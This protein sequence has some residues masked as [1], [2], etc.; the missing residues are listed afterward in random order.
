MSVRDEYFNFE[1]E[2]EQPKDDLFSKII[3]SLVIVFLLVAIVAVSIIS[4]KFISNDKQEVKNNLISN[5]T[6]QQSHPKL[7][8]EQKEKDNKEQKKNIKAIVE[9]KSNTQALKKE[10]I[11]LI[12]KAVLEQ[13]QKNSQKVVRANI[14]DNQKKEESEDSKLLSSLQQ[15]RPDIEEKKQEEQKKKIEKVKKKIV[16]KKIKDKIIRKHITYNAVIIDNKAVKSID[17]LSKLYAKINR[18][19]KR[20]K[21][22]ILKNAYT[23]KI[24]KEIIIRQNAMRIITVRKGDTLGSIARRAYGKASMYKKI[25][26][27]NP[28]ILSNPHSLKVGMKLRVPR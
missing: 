26:K 13:M 20:K 7:A 11:A 5:Q 23:K 3:K 24:R 2:D 10:E 18:I 28:D 8:V 19:S 21:K 6:I 1:I 22:K 14:K 15:I 16:H 25:L 27:A 12:V 4:Y 17:E 9:P